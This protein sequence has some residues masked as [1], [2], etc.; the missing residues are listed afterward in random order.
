MSGLLPPLTAGGEDHLSASTVGWA[1]AEGFVEAAEF[2]RRMKDL[3]AA[4]RSE[5]P[6]PGREVMLPGDPEKKA[7]A[8]R[9]RE[10]IPVDPLTWKKFGELT[11]EFGVPLQVTR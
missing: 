5:P 7:T 10:G 9:S 11:A 1:L 4:V 2:P 6:Q 8:L 3:M